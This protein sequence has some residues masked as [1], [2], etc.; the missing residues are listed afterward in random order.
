MLPLKRF[1]TPEAIKIKNNNRTPNYITSF[2]VIKIK[3][4]QLLHLRSDTGL[5]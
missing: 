2:F 1:S 5:E 4:D 3:K